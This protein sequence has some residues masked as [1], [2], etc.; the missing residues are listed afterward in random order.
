MERGIGKGCWQSHGVYI[1]SAHV[2]HSSIYHQSLHVPLDSVG[3]LADLSNL[4]FLVI[5]WEY[6]EHKMA[7]FDFRFDLVQYGFK[8]LDAT[9]ALLYWVLD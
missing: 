8:L 6:G 5:W 3:E 1:R 2:Y 7:I 4:I 9:M